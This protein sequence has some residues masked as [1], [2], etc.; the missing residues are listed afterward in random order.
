MPVSGSY[1]Y[2]VLQSPGGSIKLTEKA[3]SNAASLVSGSAGTI[4]DATDVSA[5]SNIAITLSNGAGSLG[6]VAVEFSPN[7]SDWEDWDS[8]TFSSLAADTVLSLQIAG[9][10]RN[11]LRIRSTDTPAATA[12]T[13]SLHMNNG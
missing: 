1:H 4:L 9:N 7:N 13:A 8:S 6:T 12:V 3:V 2:P 10:S 5:W 11:Y